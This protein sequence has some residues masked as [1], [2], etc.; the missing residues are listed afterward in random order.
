MYTT[1]GSD[2]TE[3]SVSYKN[4]TWCSVQ[5]CDIIYDIFTWESKTGYNARVGYQFYIN[6]GN[7]Y[8]K[9]A[10]PI[11]E[12]ATNPGADHIRYLTPCLQVNKYMTVGQYIETD[13][14]NGKEDSFSTPTPFDN[15][16]FSNVVSKE[17]VV[18]PYGAFDA[19][20]II[21]SHSRFSYG[22]DGNSYAL[23]LIHI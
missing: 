22:Q 16:N 20:K 12:F 21:T 23:S 18:T 19:F 2:I 7:V 4:L 8:L 3:N 9:R 1:I 10:K 6:Q 17:L 15:W 14:K 11:Y 13:C 5:N